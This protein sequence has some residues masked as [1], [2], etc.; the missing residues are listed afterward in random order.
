MSGEAFLCQ[1]QD[2]TG[3]NRQHDM[4]R[5]HYSVQ[6]VSQQQQQRA[7]RWGLYNALYMVYWCNLLL[8]GTGQRSLGSSSSNSWCN[9]QWGFTKRCGW[10]TGMS[11]EAWGL[12]LPSKGPGST[13]LSSTAGARGCTT[14]RAWCTG[15]SGVTSLCQIRDS[16]VA[17]AAAAVGAGLGA[18]HSTVPGLL[19]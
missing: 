15:M 6:R 4:S 7:Q 14:H 16:A 13:F 1:V 3:E 19:A 12:P 5:C 11:G 9:M 10:L 8:L 2:S 18:S 17:A